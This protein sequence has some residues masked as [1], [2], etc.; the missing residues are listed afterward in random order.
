[1][2]APT[3]KPGPVPLSLMIRFTASI[4]DLPL[5]VPSPASTTV[6]SLKRRIRENLPSHSAARRLRLIHSGKVLTDA[7]LLSTALR[8]SSLPPPPRNKGKGKGRATASS[9]AT[10]QEQDGEEKDTEDPPTPQVYVHC[11]VGDELTLEELAQEEAAAAA[12]AAPPVPTIAD[13]K[14]LA[15][16][17]TSR[18]SSTTPAPRGFDRLLSAGFTP[19]EVSSL[20]RQFVQLQA[21]TH[22]PDE[23]PTAAE[24]RALEDQWIDES[25]GPGGTLGVGDGVAGDAGSGGG[26][27]DI[28]IG[29]VVGFFWP[30]GVIWLLREEG[31]WS[32]RRQMAV[33]T[34][35]LINLAFS[36]LRVTN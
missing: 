13:T 27:E 10:E 19:E 14:T 30:I 36:V 15:A 4:P 12:S 1:M 9:F 33:F 25:A 32:G 22:T 2:A 3:S 35:L 24:M 31:V 20:R 11:S 6:L 34:G 21:H 17:G 28:L 5:I 18:I 8:L 7:S 26:Y 29:N 23:M 16:S